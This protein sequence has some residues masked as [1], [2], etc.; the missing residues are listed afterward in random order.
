MAQLTTAR[1]LQ[2]IAIIHSATDYH[3]S[4]LL[5]LF[6][7]SPNVE[8][9]LSINIPEAFPSHFQSIE[10]NIIHL[11]HIYLHINFLLSV[12]IFWTLIKHN[13]GRLDIQYT[14]IEHLSNLDACISE[15]SINWEAY[16]MQSQHEI[17]SCV[18]L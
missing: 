17:E 2:L 3:S 18:H 15:K 1:T 12:S 9:N 14:T 13:H 11:I 8:T 7:I 6:Y 16:L 10:Q 4:L 5:L